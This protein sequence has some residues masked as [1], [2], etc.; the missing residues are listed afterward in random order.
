MALSDE[1]RQCIAS[2]RD[3]PG[4]HELRDRID[5]D[6]EPID[7][8]RIYMLKSLGAVMQALCALPEFADSKGDALF[9]LHDLAQALIGLD[10]GRRSELLETRKPTFPK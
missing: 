2:H 10:E 3:R 7:V 8:A 9:P 1:Y 6:A 5:A 4:S